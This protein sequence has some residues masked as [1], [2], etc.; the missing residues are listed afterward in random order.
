[1]KDTIKKITDIVTIVVPAV[2]A[3]LGVLG[4]TGATDTINKAMGVFLTICGALSST[5]SVTYNQVT[6]MPS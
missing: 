3:V 4:I 2:I 1:M 5:A 6:K